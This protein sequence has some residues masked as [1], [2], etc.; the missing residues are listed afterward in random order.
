M[1]LYDTAKGGRALL[2]ESSERVELA[3]VSTV[4]AGERELSWLD[5]SLF[6]DLSPDGKTALF[7][8][9]GEGGG[10]KYSVYLRKLDGSA[11]VRLGDG[12]AS[13]L[14]P[15]GEWVAAFDTHHDPPIPILLLPTGAGQ[16]RKLTS[17]KL[18]YRNVAWLPDSKSLLITAKE[19]GKPVRVF[20]QSIDAGEPRPLTPEGYGASRNLVAPDGKTFVARQG[21]S[22]K[23]L[24]WPISGGESGKEIPGLEPADVMLRWSADGRSIFTYQNADRKT[25]L[26]TR[27]DVATGKRQVVKEWLPADRAGVTGYFSAGI[28]TD[29]KTI[30]Y[31]YNR[32]VGDLYLVE[33]LR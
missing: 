24:L 33:G 7:S 14:S 26:I 8:E 16:T 12:T 18:D 22:G 23:R 13:A 29:G 4:E 10:P 5:W 3:A 17:D 19:A 25:M 31:S 9:A 30:V 21:A 28:S 1:I 27:V 32:V 11:A 6:A 2:T 15:D 20:L